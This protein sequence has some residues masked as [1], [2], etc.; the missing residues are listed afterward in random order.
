M[1]DLKRLIK[2]LEDNEATARKFHAVETRILSILNFK[3]LF[4][5]LLSEIHTTFH[6]SYS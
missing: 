3:D 5:V 4:E 6:Q 1:V 2:Q